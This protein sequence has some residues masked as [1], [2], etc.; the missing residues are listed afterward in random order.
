MLQAN[1]I[2]YVEPAP[3]TSTEIFQQIAPIVGII[4]S[5]ALVITIIKAL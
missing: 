3:Q 2:I 4:T 5:I 1:D